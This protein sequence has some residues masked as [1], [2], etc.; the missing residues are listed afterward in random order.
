[1]IAGFVVRARCESRRRPAPETPPS[2]DP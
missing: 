1:L 2:A